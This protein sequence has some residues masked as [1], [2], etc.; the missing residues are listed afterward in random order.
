MTASGL[1]A[2]AAF[3]QIMLRE[4]IK[5]ILDVVINIFD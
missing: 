1:A 3:E 2:I 5:T 4:N